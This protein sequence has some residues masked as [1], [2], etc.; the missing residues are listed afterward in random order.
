MQFAQKILL[1][2]GAATPKHLTFF[3]R[4]Q[5]SASDML[6]TITVE[7]SKID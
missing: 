2:V 1:Y 5:A 6:H 4:A 3:H 7:P